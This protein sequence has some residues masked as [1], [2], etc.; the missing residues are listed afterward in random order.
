[1]SQNNND[2]MFSS[3]V[4]RKGRRRKVANYLPL[5]KNTAY[6]AWQGNLKKFKL[7]DAGE[8]ID[9]NNKL[10]FNSAGQLKPDA[11]DYWMPTGSTGS[12]DADPITGFTSFIELEPGEVDTTI[13]A[14]FF[15]G[16]QI[17]NFVWEDAASAGSIPNIQDDL[18]FGFGGAQVFLFVDG[19]TTPIDSTLTD[20]N[21]AYLFTDLV[22]GDYRVQFIAPAAFV[23]VD[24]NVGSDDAIDS[25]ANPTDGFSP[26]ITLAA[27]ESNLTIDA[28]LRLP[29]VPVTLADFYGVHNEDRDV[30]EL[31][32]ITETELNSDFFVVERQFANGDFRE[33]GTVQAAGNSISAIT[34]NLDD[35]DIAQSGIY[36]YRLKQVDLDGSF[37]Y[38]KIIAIKVERDDVFDVNMYPNPT[39]G[40][41]TL[42][43]TLNVSDDIAVSI[44]DKSGKFIM[45]Q[46]IN[47]QDVSEFNSII[48]DVDALTSGVYNTVIRTG[49]N[50]IVKQLI[51][52]E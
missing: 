46:V 12:T 41:V 43:I 9:A 30:N 15:L 32:W 39:A 50:I 19:S 45:E 25:D 36:Y 22:P 26:V 20:G 33:I 28:G 37:E 40:F 23:F 6:P 17:G 16:A 13:D 52:L 48:L 4:K 8:I 1:M 11:V 14:G 29:P 21:G 2:K 47:K 34:Y 51:I 49:G 18:D 10:A 31:T 27:G 7:N 24:P 42:D 44:Y 3:F 5:F 38:S 35:A